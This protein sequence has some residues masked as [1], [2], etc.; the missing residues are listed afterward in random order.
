MRVRLSRDRSIVSMLTRCRIATA[1]T[2][3]E[4][5]RAKNLLKTTMLLMLNGSTAICEDI[6]R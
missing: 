2:D 3:I 6:G 4:V 5:A 1:C